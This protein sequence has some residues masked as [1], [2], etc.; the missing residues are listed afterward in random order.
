MGTSFLLLLLLTC[1]FGVVRMIDPAEPP[2]WL[3]LLTSIL[4]L[5]LGAVVLLFACAFWAMG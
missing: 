5:L 4:L 2:R 3:R 1:G